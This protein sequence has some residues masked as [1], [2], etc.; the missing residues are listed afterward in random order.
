MKIEELVD[1]VSAIYRAERDE[2]YKLKQEL[3]SIERSLMEAKETNFE[4]ISHADY[5]AFVTRGTILKQN[6]CLK[7]EHYKGISCIREMLM[8]LGFDT[9]INM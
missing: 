5:Q 2:V 8:D 1:K 6:I 4:N 9:D 7:T 3:N